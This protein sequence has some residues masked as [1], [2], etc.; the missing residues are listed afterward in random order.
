MSVYNKIYT[1]IMGLLIIILL[2]GSLC[3]KVSKE[4]LVD[5]GNQF[6]GQNQHKLDSIAGLLASLATNDAD[7]YNVSIAHSF[8]GISSAMQG[9]L[10][11]S[12]QSFQESWKYAVSLNDTNLQVNALINMAGVYRFA[13]QLN[14]AKEKLNKALDLLKGEGQMQTRA[15]T[16]L[17]LGII[18]FKRS[19]IS[20]LLETLV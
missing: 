4:E 8:D 19:K 9:D 15:N 11:P 7:N 6:V 14:K 18:P 3:S 5:L 20:V 13:G 2:N 12:L 10:G 17:A 16:L 1:G